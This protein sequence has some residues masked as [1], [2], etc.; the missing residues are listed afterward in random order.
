M[1]I[2]GVQIY[3]SLVN[4]ELCPLDRHVTE[5]LPPFRR[6]L[7]IQ[8]STRHSPDIILISYADSLLK[9]HK[10]N[11]MEILFFRA[12][13]HFFPVGGQQNWNRID[14]SEGLWYWPKRLGNRKNDS[15]L[16]PF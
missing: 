2:R 12:M 14:E 9:I 10:I 6:S 11:E 13:V 15:K 7:G 16:Q 3:T 5:P 4:V 8:L 1:C